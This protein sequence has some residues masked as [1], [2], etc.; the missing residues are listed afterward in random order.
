MNTS[1]NSSTI[2][3]FLT[4]AGVDLVLRED[5]VETRARLP[6]ESLKGTLGTDAVTVKFGDV[7]ERLTVQI[8]DVLH[9]L[10]QQPKGHFFAWLSGYEASP[11]IDV[12]Q[13]RKLAMLA[14]KKTR[15]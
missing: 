13:A 4:Q 12:A 3:A 11:R 10:R 15:Q 14:G 7:D 8:G 1:L 5:D 6:Y 9:S 2:S